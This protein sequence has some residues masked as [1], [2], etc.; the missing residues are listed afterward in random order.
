MS[1][2]SV[3]PTQQQEESLVV[4]DH[5]PRRLGAGPLD[6][7]RKE[8]WCPGRHTNDNSAPPRA[9]DTSQR[10]A[11]D[12]NHDA[13]HDSSKD[14]AKMSSNHLNNFGSYIILSTHRQLRNRMFEKSETCVGGGHD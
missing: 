10:L 11:R 13:E 2:R 5:L 12:E 1:S 4:F 6:L 3:I 9:V 7:D 14:D 8:R